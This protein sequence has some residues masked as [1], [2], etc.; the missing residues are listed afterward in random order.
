MNEKPECIGTHQLEDE[1]LQHTSIHKTRFTIH[2]NHAVKI[3]SEKNEIIIY[4]HLILFIS[5]FKGIIKVICL[6]N[7]P[8]SPSYLSF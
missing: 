6:K 4:F 3:K 1:K 7:I 8:H 5:S 2:H